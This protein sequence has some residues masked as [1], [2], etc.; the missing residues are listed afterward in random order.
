MN[1]MNSTQPWDDFAPAIL[2]QLGPHDDAALWQLAIETIVSDAAHTCQRLPPNAS[3]ILQIG[4]CSHW[5]AP[6][7][8]RW[9]TR[10]GDEFAWPSGYKTKNGF[11]GGLPEFDWELLFSSDRNC[12]EWENVGRIR[13]KRPFL[14]RIAIPARTRLHL[15][16]SV[17]AMWTPGPRGDLDPGR[18]FYGFR[19]VQSVW[20]LKAYGGPKVDRT[21]VASGSA[22]I[23]R[24]ICRRK[25]IP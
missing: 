19:M 10:A 20:R 15:R 22:Q 8:A 5:L 7:K 11:F 13:S 2:E 3:L 6:S 17:V 21:R 1:R 14:L 4:R 16:A 24:R 23:E 25:S 9:I 12:R 18:L